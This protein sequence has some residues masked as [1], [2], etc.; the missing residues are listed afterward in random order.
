MSSS[1]FCLPESFK[2]VQGLCAIGTAGALTADTVSLKNA[3]KAWIIVDLGLPDSSVPSLVPMRSL[4]VGSAGAVLVNAVPIWLNDDVTATD[5]LV[6]QTAAVNFTITSVTAVGKQVIFEIDPANLGG[7]YDC[8][9]IVVGTAGSL[10]VNEAVSVTYLL[11]T[12]YPQATPP[13]AITD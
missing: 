1:N 6:R 8:I 9:Y 11:E 5:T 3:Q 10:T 12:R 7:A 4:A 13:A 2:V